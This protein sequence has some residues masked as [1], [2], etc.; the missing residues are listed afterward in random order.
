VGRGFFPLDERLELLPGNLSP[1][2]HECSVRLGAWIPF[3]PVA[4]LLKDILGV[5]VSKASVV[6]DTEAAGAAYVAVQTEAA[7]WIEKEAPPAP[8][9]ASKMVI[10]VDGAMVPLQHGEWGE[11][12]TLAVG[13]VPPPV[14]ECGELVVH[15]QKLSYF[16]RL[17]T[18]ERFQHLTLVEMHG[19]GVEHCQQVGAV[20]DGAEWE[21]G[22]LDYHHPQAVRILDFPHAGQR[23]GEIGQVCFGENN[24]ETSQWISER[25]HQLKYQGPDN[26]L[27][28][29]N[30]LHQQHPQSEVIAEN[31]LYLEKRRLQM[32]YPQFQ[33]QGWPIGSGMV[34][35]ANK[36][37]VEA[38]LKGAG[39]HWKRENVDPM[40]ALRNIICSDRWSEEWPLIAQQLRREVKQRSQALRQRHRLT[41]AP[42]PE[43]VPLSPIQ[44]AMP[45]PETTEPSLDEQ[46][47]Q[48]KRSYGPGRPA[49]NHPWKHS[50]IGRLL[51]Q[52][53]TSAKK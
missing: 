2:C 46:L 40:L 27:M 42:S 8:F 45:E 30:Q 14:M 37:V 12:K 5:Q 10:S 44:E 24:P 49:A 1:Y 7:D 13:E 53:T 43:P 23:I 16:S 17:A 41:K 11:V 4:Q 21:Q 33:A 20:T 39:M 50:P 48:P 32:Q 51:Y 9:G 25:L 6:R 34:E 19:R 28:E 47:T 31:L 15:T 3:E 18:A 26:L 35:S 38:R 52:P 36:L 29:L 22:F